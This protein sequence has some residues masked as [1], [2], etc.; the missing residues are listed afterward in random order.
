M[1]TPEVVTRFAAV[2]ALWLTDRQ[3]ESAARIRVECTASTDDVNDKFTTKMTQT[4]LT[5]VVA[6]SVVNAI[7]AAQSMS[8]AG[9]KRRMDG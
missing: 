7:Q 4:G 8:A 1:L 6:G 2:A 9:A 3:S 5:R